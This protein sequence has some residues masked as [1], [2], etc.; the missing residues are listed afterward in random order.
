MVLGRE[1]IIKY[2]MERIYPKDWLLLSRE[3]RK[4][5]VDGLGLYKTGNVEIVDD[6]VVSDG[7]TMSDLGGINIETMTKYTGHEMLVPLFNSL[8]NETLKKVY[9][10][11]NPIPIVEEV[12]PLTKAPSCYY[13]DTK[14]PFSHKKDC[15]R[16]NKNN[17][18][19]KIEGS[20]KGGDIVQPD[21]IEGEKVSET[22]IP[23]PTE[24]GDSV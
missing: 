24:T 20:I 14:V 21:I 11:L 16:P 4:V 17:E 13:C 15:A 2:N 7:Y 9:F 12:K 6:R 3:T 5:I 19:T 23:I 18:T 10:I 8:W 1:L 22:D